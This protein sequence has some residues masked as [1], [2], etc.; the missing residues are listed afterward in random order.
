MMGR[1]LTSYLLCSASMLYAGTALAQ[2]AAPPPPSPPSNTVAEIVVTAQKRSERLSDVPLSITASTGEQLKKQGITDPGQLEK[3]VPGFTYTQS[4]YGAPIFAIRG[5][6]F[7]D[8]SVEISPTVSVYVD[9]VPIPFSK[10]TEAAGLDI[11][12]VEVLKGPQ[13]TLFG[14]NA[15]GG[16]I[17][18]IA[19]KPT[20]YMTEGASVDYGRFNDINVDG[21]VSG[22]I[23]D[24]LGARLS[25]RTE[26]RDGWQ[27]STSRDATLGRRDF[28]TGRLLLDW[29]PAGAVKFEL[30][31]NGWKDRSDTQ[32]LQFESYSV[33]SLNP[34]AGSAE[35]PN[36]QALLKALPAAPANARAADWDPGESFARNDSYF[37]ISLRGDWDITPNIKLTSISTYANLNANDPVDFDGTQYPDISV[38]IEAATR[39]FS[40]ELRLAGTE[41]ENDRIHWMLGGNYQHDDTT[42]VQRLSIQGSNS[43]VGPF[44]WV[45]FFNVNLQKVDT[46]AG[47]ASLDYKLTDTLT[48]Q[49][50]VR[51]TTQDR[52]FHGCLQDDGD[53]AMTTAF[54]FLSNLLNGH[55][56][57]ALPGSAAYIAPGSCVTLDPV[58]NLPLGLV[59]KTL[60]ESNTSWRVGL[61]WKP[62]SD[63]MVYAN[64]TKGFKAGSFGTLPAIRPNQLDPVPQEA[65]L[66]YEIG[67]KTTVL[68]RKVQL[69][70]AAFYY[71][72][73]DKQELGIVAEPFFGTLPGLVTIPK[74]RV[75]G[76][77]LDA[78][79]RATKELTLSAGASFVDSSVLSDSTALNPGVLKDIVS[80]KGSEFPDTPRWQL[81]TDGE[82]RFPWANKGDVYFGA[83]VSYRSDTS[84]YFAA[85]PEFKIPSYALLDLRAG[86]ETADGR[87]GI[88]F[89]GHNV[90][91]RYYWV[92]VADSL[93]TIARTAGLPVTYGVKLSA[94]F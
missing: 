36:L 38:R 50:S 44:R 88:Q 48:A 87:W 92:N 86:F 34:Y 16:A 60:D 54:G 67:F 80:I 11:E 42:D 90:T 6:G 71:D 89:Y 65:V 4:S 19:A 1:R 51:Y 76:A 64:V 61:S 94:H 47:F 39:T 9:Q 74:S 84:S 27:Q 78:H 52:D 3:V 14:Q 63:F 35:Y 20:K 69:T 30:N 72:Y 40:Q 57:P 55:P 21:Y 45:D 37:Q 12:R 66:A 93:D 15:T 22:P 32:A 56:A 82:Y 77:E 26:Q 2:Q 10:G 13:G 79:W 49:G 31:I 28:T 29:Q 91:N 24:T 68:N 18:Y 8:E 25:A 58:T 81:S 59:H 43:G 46:K 17:N 73:T 5:I 23:T 33:G 53:G 75:E 70:G 62:M 83:N 7:Y 85:G 41:G